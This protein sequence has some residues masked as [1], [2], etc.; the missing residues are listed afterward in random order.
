MEG[1]RKSDWYIWRYGKPSQ[2]SLPQQSMEAELI[3]K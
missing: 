3:E 1:E 2:P